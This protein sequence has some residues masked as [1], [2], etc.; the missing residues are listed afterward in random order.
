MAQKHEQAGT[1]AERRQRWQSPT[2]ERIGKFGAVMHGGSRPN[3]DP[4]S[5]MRKA[6]NG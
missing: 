5:L 1:G 6:A 2:I 3:P 4:G